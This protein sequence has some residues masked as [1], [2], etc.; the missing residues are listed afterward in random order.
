M[1]YI[2]YT[3]ERKLNLNMENGKHNIINKYKDSECKCRE[4]VGNCLHR[5]C[6]PT[7]EEIEA[8]INNG[9]A[10]RLMLDYWSSNKNIKIVAPAIV[11]YEGDDA[12]FWPRGRCTFLTTDNLCEL[13]DLS[14]KP[15]EGRVSICN[16][17]QP[18]LHE[19]VAKMWDD[20][21][22]RSVILKW[23]KAIE[24]NKKKEII[25][26]I[27][28]KNLMSEKEIDEILSMNKYWEEVTER[29]DPSPLH[30]ELIQVCRMFGT[31]ILWVLADYA[32]T[33]KENMENEANPPL[34]EY[35]GKKP[36]VNLMC[37]DCY[38]SLDGFIHGSV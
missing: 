6:W 1:I 34:C 30:H 7:P 11:G 14:L 13:H 36:G 4:C 20:R 38:A 15:F 21:K 19:D 8:L 22:G 33:Q 17:K 2:Y 26:D 27:K 25:K 31:K 12:P 23:R 28:M 16:L 5:P 29:D 10:K 24:V 37:D 32:K 18:D 3:L 9:Y 35:C